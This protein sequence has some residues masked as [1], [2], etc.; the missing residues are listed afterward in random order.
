MLGKIIKNLKN[1]QIRQDYI[2]FNHNIF[3][4]NKT[5]GKLVLIEF[6]AFHESHVCQSLFSNFLAKKYDLNIVGYFNYCILSAPLNQTIFQKI[7]W[8]LGKFFNYKYHAIY[9]SFGSKY[10]IRPKINK[11][12]K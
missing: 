11:D 2:S 7:K 3:K 10:V 5:S 12:K 9:K 8:N 6:N 4:P 1:Y